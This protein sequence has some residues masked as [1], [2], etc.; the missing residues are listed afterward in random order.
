MPRPPSAHAH[1]AVL[2]AALKLIADCGIEGTS[3]DAI[4]EVSSVSK[5]TI[6][7]HWKNKEALCLEA[8]G[9]LKPDLP[10]FR[11][12]DPRKDAVALLQHLA[13]SQKPEALGRIWPRIM[14]YA[15]GHP[16]FARAFCVHISDGRHSQI[17]DLLKRAVS[18]GEL[19]PDVDV[20]LALDLLI[21][22][23]LYRRFMHASVPPNL[24]EQV[25][26]AYWR[27]HAPHGKQSLKKAGRKKMTPQ[28]LQN[29]LNIQPSAARRSSS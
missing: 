15:A 17:S 2:E 9:R 29:T 23:V 27:A 6:Y 11:S 19:S 1:E 16:E 3:V 13:R 10:L 24:P 8:I 4:A 25:V 20:D 21:G 18:K 26:D 28:T 14:T 22:P 7:K 12:P 5:A